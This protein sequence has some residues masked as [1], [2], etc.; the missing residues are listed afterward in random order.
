MLNILLMTKKKN[1]ALLSIKEYQFLMQ[2]LEDLEDTLEM[3][4]AVQTGDGSRSSRTD[5]LCRD[6]T[7][8]QEN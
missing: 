3:N 1:S 4:V 2:R 6:I 8:G 5:G 7:S